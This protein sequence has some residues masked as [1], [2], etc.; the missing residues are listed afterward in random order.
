YA[1]EFVVKVLEDLADKLTGLLGFE[2]DLNGLVARALDGHAW[3]GLHRRQGQVGNGIQQFTDADIF[4]GGGAEDRDDG[5]RG[6]RLGQ[7]RLQLRSAYSALHEIFFH[8]GLGGFEDG[9]AKLGTRGGDT[10]GTS[11]RHTVG[12]LQNTHNA[13]EIRADA[14]WRIKEDAAL[15]ER[16]LDGLEQ[17]VEVDIV[18]IE[19]V[20]D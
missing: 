17:I 4:L 8:Q 11:R 9:I 5:P 2:R 6:Q 19:A 13:F 16:I 18:G 1:D 7:S 3:L 20:D 15:A 10:P 14:D 12:R